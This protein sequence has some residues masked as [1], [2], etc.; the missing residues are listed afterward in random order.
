M[1]TCRFWAFCEDWEL[2]EPADSGRRACF[3]GAA[4]KHSKHKL[5]EFHAFDGHVLN[6]QAHKV[7]SGSTSTSNDQE[8]PTSDLH[9]SKVWSLRD[10]AY[11]VLRLT[12]H[13]GIH[14]QSII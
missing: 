4:D 12:L 10:F 14:K 1:G 3:G 8:V 2:C 9:T 11:G 7:G 5:A 6:V 13:A